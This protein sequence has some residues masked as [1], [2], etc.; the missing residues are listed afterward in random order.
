MPGTNNDGN[1]ECCGLSDG[2]QLPRVKSPTHV[3]QLC[4][5]VYVG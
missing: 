1:G 3:S 2:V 5:Q 4:C